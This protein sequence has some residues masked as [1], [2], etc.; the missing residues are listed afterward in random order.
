MTATPKPSPTIHALH[1]VPVPSQGLKDDAAESRRRVVM[2]LLAHGVTATD[3]LLEI[4][5]YIELG[6]DESEATA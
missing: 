5:A 2:Q 6:P 3:D 1:A 4:A